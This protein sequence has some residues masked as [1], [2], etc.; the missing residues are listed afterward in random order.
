[1]PRLDDNDAGF[2][3]IYSKHP[4]LWE[5]FQVQWGTLWEYGSLE[6]R[7]RDLIRIKSAT[8]HACDF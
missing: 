3:G 1:M 6:P 4:E 2:A 7:I 5:A 8:L